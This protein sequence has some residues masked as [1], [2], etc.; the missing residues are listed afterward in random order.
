[1]QGGRGRREGGRGGTARTNLALPA[2]FRVGLMRL[3]GSQ[4]SETKEAERR[5]AAAQGV[6]N[7]RN[8]FV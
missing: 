3:S 4:R 8:R 1:M 7:K 2:A 6:E 5:T